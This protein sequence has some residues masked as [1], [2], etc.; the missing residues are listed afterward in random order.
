MRTEIR[1]GKGTQ[2]TSEVHTIPL[3][4]IPNLYSLLISG[5]GGSEA[6]LCI[7]KSLKNIYIYIYFPKGRAEVRKGLMPCSE[8]SA[9]DS[10]LSALQ[11]QC[12]HECD[13]ILKNRKRF[14][15][16]GEKVLTWGWSGNQGSLFQKG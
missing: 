2:L 13:A 3:Y 10:R 7:N 9:S 14:G 8:D 12:G 4:T 6:D 11:C 15:R 5:C 1:N 16:N